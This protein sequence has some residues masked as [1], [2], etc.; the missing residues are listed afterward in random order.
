[1]DREGW[2]ANTDI[3]VLADPARRTLLWIPRDVWS[4]RLG[5]RV[6]AAFTIG[7]HG[8]LIAALA[9]LGHRADH[10]VCLSR[11]ATTQALRDVSV[12]VPVDRPLQ[13]RYPLA[14]EQPI[15]DGE[16]VVRFDP[17]AETLAGERVHQWIGARF[18]V[19]RASGDLHRIARQQVLLRALLDQ[20]FDFARVVADPES[21]SLSDPRALDEL[22]VVDG[23]W[24]MR[25]LTRLRPR[26][27][28]GKAVLVRDP[29]WRPSLA[30]RSL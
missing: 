28:D 19:D 9:E 21:I 20:R 7:S 16:K 10:S 23:D 15:E 24:R 11:T 18:E 17:P 30:R 6:N 1:M 13:F 4:P 3:I 29:W 2:E 8:A 22:R 12:R 25:T 27:I 26:T 14:P 5:D